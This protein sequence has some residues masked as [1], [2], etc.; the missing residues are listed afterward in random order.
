MLAVTSAASALRLAACF[1][2]SFP[3]D[4]FGTPHVMV[5]S[6]PLAPFGPK[7]FAQLTYWHAATLLPS[8][9]VISPRWGLLSRARRSLPQSALQVGRDGRA[10]G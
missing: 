2:Q 4:D 1:D 3:S 5:G 10:G 8:C 6:M 9:T 7:L